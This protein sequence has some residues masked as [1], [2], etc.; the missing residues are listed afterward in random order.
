MAVKRPRP[1]SLASPLPSYGYD[2]RGR[3]VRRERGNVVKRYDEKT[4]G[5]Y[6]DKSA[7]DTSAGKT[8]ERD[9]T[10]G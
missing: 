3:V 7:G 5:A 10:R 4:V 8:R 9:Q 2:E 1:A 6:E